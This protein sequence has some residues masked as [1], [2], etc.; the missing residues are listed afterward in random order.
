[1]HLGS[2]TIWTCTRT[3]NQ[4][5]SWSMNCLGHTTWVVQTL[6]HTH[7]WRKCYKCFCSAQVNKDFCQPVM[8]WI[9]SV[10]VIHFRQNGTSIIC[11]AKVR[12]A[13]KLT[14]VKT[15][16]EKTNRHREK[17]LWWEKWTIYEMKRL[18]WLWPVTDMKWK[19]VND[20]CD[21]NQSQTRNEK[22][23]TSVTISDKKV[24]WRW[25]R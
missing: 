8:A 21:D 2:D 25:A 24:V 14:D 4:A 18:L 19:D 20:C 16:N 1:M 5:I 11:T 23:T 22:W 10:S 7:F 6:L 17:V 9:T 3:I 12:Q 15:W 13:L